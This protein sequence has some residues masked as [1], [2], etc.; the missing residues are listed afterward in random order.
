MVEY[1][2]TVL[3]NYNNDI[4]NNYFQDNSVGLDIIIMHQGGNSIWIKISP[5]KANYLP[6]RHK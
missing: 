5:T 1:D 2:D 4:V 3:I 6:V